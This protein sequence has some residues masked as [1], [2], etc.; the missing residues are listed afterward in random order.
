MSALDELAHGLMLGT[1]RGAPPLPRLS[2]RLGALID[3][4]CASASA[5][6]PEQALLRG[7]GVLAVYDAAASLPAPSDVPAAARCEDEMRPIAGQPALVAVLRRV[8]DEGPDPLRREALALLA[9][10]NCLLAP[11][12]LPRALSLG[13]RQA[14][15]RPALAAALGRR[16]AWLARRRT[17]WQWAVAAAAGVEDELDCWQ[18]G[19]AEQRRELF[20]RWRTAAPAPA[21]ERLAAEFGRLDARERAALLAALAVGLSA[22]DEDFVEAR[23]GDRSREVRRVAARLLSCLPDSRYAARMGGRMQAC[24]AIKRRL[25]R[26]EPTL[27]PPQAADETWKND[28]PD[29]ERPKDE[30]LGE[31][32]WWLY[33]VARSLPLDWWPQATG[34]DP[35]RLLAWAHSSDWRQSLLRAWRERLEQESN[36]ARCEAVLAAGAIKGLT[37]DPLSLIDKLPAER[38]ERHWT[39]RLEAAGDAAELGAVA[40]RIIDAQAAAGPTLWP[41]LSRRLLA[42]LAA[43]PKPQLRDD[44][45]LRRK[46]PELASLVAPDCLDAAAAMLNAGHDD[47]PLM[48]EAIATSLAVLEQRKILFQFLSE[49]TSP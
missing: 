19:T 27:E 39:Q 13:R 37:I 38:R 44:Y 17:D 14:A 4:G 18:H 31:R 16:G 23:L 30:K 8:L 41:G 25:L 5:A 10:A 49:R 36:E 33:Q 34:M 9:E 48:Q 28:V 3:A 42:L 35:A 47:H 22:A 29:A 1:E 26:S 24:L 43:I 12:L 15:L 7:A 20:V 21:R 11:G 6:A 32:A 45:V 2:G 46:L 40:S